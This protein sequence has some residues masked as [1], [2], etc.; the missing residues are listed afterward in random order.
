MTAAAIAAAGKQPRPP[1][2][3]NW[4]TFSWQIQMVVNNREKWLV[5]NNIVFIWTVDESWYQS[6][7][8][9]K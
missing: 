7:C 4:A 8:Y 1:K 5:T 2:L 9:K 3:L 6:Y